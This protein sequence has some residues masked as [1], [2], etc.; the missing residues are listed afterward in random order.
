MSHE[1]VVSLTQWGNQQK[2]G[3]QSKVAL[4]LIVATVPLTQS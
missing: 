2:T 3:Y 1:T 4:I